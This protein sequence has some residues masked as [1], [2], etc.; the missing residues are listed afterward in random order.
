MKKIATYIIFFLTMSFGSTLLAQIDENLLLSLT[1][2]T[3]LEM[4][5]ITNMPTGALIFNSTEKWVYQYNGASWE[6]LITT[7][8][9]PK[10]I[11]KTGDYTLKASDNGSVFTFDNT[12]DMRLTIPSDLPIGFNISI[13]QI[14]AGKVFFSGS[15]GVE[16]KNRLSRFKTAGKDA[17]VGLIFTAK[18]TVYLTGDLKK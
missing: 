16:L 5:A 10:V 1:N 17:G 9:L 8:I 14:D 3:T 18:N 11:I 6:K 2:A 13:Y 4:N 7:E 12:S 15:G